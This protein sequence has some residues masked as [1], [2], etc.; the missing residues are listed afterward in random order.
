MNEPIPHKQGDTFK[1]SCTY[2]V[3]GVAAAL[4][5]GIRSQIRYCGVLVVELDVDRVDPPNGRYDL[6]SSD[7]TSEWPVDTLDQDIQYT[8]AA[9]DV[10]STETFSVRVVRDVTHD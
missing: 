3:D 5:D 4:P 2:M 6:S 7:D 8:T 9:G 10:F 1:L